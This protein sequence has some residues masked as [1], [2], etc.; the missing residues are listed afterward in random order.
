[1]TYQQAKFVKDLVAAKTPLDKIAEQFYNQYGKTE[2][3]SGPKA[4]QYVKNK[5]QI[6]YCN[7]EGNDIKSAAS[8]VL[9]EKL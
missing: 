4:V 2:Y 8:F 6:S 3:C 7:F 5:K 1:M 9:K